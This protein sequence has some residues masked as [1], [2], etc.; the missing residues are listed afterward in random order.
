MNDE[1]RK[2]TNQLMEWVDKLEQTEIYDSIEIEPPETKKPKLSLCSSASS[3]S[4]NKNEGGGKFISE[5]NLPP[6]EMTGV[7]IF[8][9][10]LCASISSRLYNEDNNIEMFNDLVPKEYF[11]VAPKKFHGQKKFHGPNFKS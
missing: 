9:T 4:S 6:E 7:S 10:K 1:L 11:V 5:K 8:L 3:S 2:K